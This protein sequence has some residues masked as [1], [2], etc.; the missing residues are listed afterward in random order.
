M[1]L[2]LV[3]GC[4]DAQAESSPPLTSEEVV[5]FID[6]VTRDINACVIDDLAGKFLNEATVT[7]IWSD[8]HKELLTKDV[9]IDRMRQHCVP[10]RIQWDRYGMQ[11]AVNGTTSTLAYDVWWHL[12]GR[13]GGRPMLVF[14]NRMELARRGFGIGIT[15]VVSRSEELVPGAERAFDTRNNLLADWEEIAQNFY[16]GLLKRVLTLQGGRHPER[17]PQ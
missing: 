5:Y 15:K 9:Y 16:H 7:F 2:A 6:N 17:A 10:E 14:H 1:P 8:G 13:N 3:V 4:A 11:F 12:P